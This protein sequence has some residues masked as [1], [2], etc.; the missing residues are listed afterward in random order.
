MIHPALCLI[1]LHMHAVEKIM[2]AF[3]FHVGKVYKISSGRSTKS[4]EVGGWLGIMYGRIPPMYSN[5]RKGRE[6]FI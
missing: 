6:C 3:S 2:P 1:A 5:G 4:I